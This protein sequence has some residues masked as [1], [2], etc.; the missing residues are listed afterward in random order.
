[1]TMIILAVLAFVFAIAAV[2]LGALY[3]ICVK[4]SQTPQTS[5]I[6]TVSPSTVTNTKTSSALVSTKTQT[7]PPLTQTVIHTETEI[8]H[9]TTE[10]TMTSVLTT[11]DTTSIT[12]TATKDPNGGQ[13]CAMNQEY[14]GQDLHHLNDDYDLLMVDAL[15]AAVSNGLDIGGSEYTDV[16]MRSIFLCSSGD[17]LELVDACESGLDRGDN[18]ITCNS[19]GAYPTRTGIATSTATATATKALRSVLGTYT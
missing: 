8:S 10:L 12:V 3:G 11:T 18:G 1:M 16:A 9:I 5:N 4:S 2:V 17:S 15:Q 14:G 7:L 6:V 19:G 13:R